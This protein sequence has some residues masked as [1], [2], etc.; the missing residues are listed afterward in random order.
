MRS[1]FTAVLAIVSLATGLAFS[2]PAEAGWKWKKMRWE[3]GHGQTYRAPHPH[4]GQG[5]YGGQRYGS[6]SGYGRYGYD[7]YSYGRPY[8]Y[9][10]PSY[11]PRHGLEW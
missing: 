1:K 5:Y 8:G 7:R 3:H 10:A 9:G 2:V 4:S 6:G 11:G